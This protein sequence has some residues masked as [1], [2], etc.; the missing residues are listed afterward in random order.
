MF[1]KHY[2]ETKRKLIKPWWRSR[3]TCRSLA[4]KGD[5]RLLSGFPMLTLAA[6]SSLE[7]HC[8]KFYFIGFL[9][10]V[11]R[12]RLTIV[13]F[14]HSLASSRRF[15]VLSLSLSFWRSLFWACGRFPTRLTAQH[16]CCVAGSVRSF[17]NMPYWSFS[18]P[19]TRAPRDRCPTRL[20]STPAGCGFAF[21]S[22][23]ESV[24]TLV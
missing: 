5:R 4:T 9:L 7:I 12:F 13:L 16:C 18:V 3:V 2:N 11:R 20:D 17:R 22:R 24:I 15:Y 8:G 23:S 10:C 1:Q 21:T 6:A 19:N 14:R